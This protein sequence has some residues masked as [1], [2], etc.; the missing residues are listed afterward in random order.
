M[1]LNTRLLAAAGSVLALVFTSSAAVQAAPP[2]PTSAPD[3]GT[4]VH[5][6]SPDMDQATIQN[7]LNSIAV[8]QVHNEF[9][10]RRDAVLFKP[11]TYGSKA[12]PLV[13]QIGY[14][15]SVAGLGLSPDDV[16]IVG[17]IEVANQCNSDG[18]FAL[19]NFWR[20][21]SNLTIDVSLA[22]APPLPATSPE[23]PG[24]V[25]SNDLYAVSQA[26]PIRRVAVNGLF[27]LFDYCGPK[28]FA[29]GGYIADSKMG[30]VI[31]GPQQQWIT[32]NSQVGVWTN[33]VWNQVFS[34]VV[35]APAQ[36]FPFT[37]LATSPVTRE[38]PFLYVNS[39][40]AYNVF[41]PAVQHDSRGNSWSGGAT[42]GVSI[43][44]ESFFVAHEGDSAETI[45][46][47]IHRGKNLILT[48][49]VYPLDQ[50]IDVTRP[51]TIVLGLGFPTLVPT[52]GNA[53]MTVASAKGILLSGLLFQAGATNSPM[54][55]QVGGAQHRSDRDATD[56]SALQDVFFR[57][58]GAA[59]GSATTSLVVNSDNVILDD[60]WSWRADHGSGVGWTVNTAGT[61]VVVN[62]DDV[63]AYGLFV[64]HY[65][66][67]NVIWNGNGGTD[68]F[69]QNE[70]PYDVPSQ[71]AWMEAPGVDGYSAFEVAPSVTSFHGY[72][73]G[74]YSFFNQGIDIF[75]AN[76]FEVPADLPAGSLR[77]LLTIFLD[78]TH[79]MGGILHVIN[80]IGGASLITNPDTPVTVVSY[81]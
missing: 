39:S 4:N 1:R 47:A 23:D 42:A 10:T 71:S 57:V 78:P 59:A 46:S 36:S 29:S 63:T 6:F 38:A 76:A 67:H 5:V 33:A 62:G 8:A 19:T 58:G 61:G 77:D 3:F 16:H 54:L 53:A 74:V 18:C 14:Y 79:G 13:F 28:Q 50:S 80:G 73:M 26:S 64:E 31:N 69:F 32:R 37:T 40:G 7:E 11:G 56:P 35:G 27:F 24:C 65:Q 22:G 55:L 21:L 81:P 45:N 60:I 17:G 66:K 25:S 43:P 9:G 48:P 52:N 51:D 41:V 75:D 12:H 49:G 34:G 70:L 20:S 44:M 68:I 72:G 30:V 15:T 2:V